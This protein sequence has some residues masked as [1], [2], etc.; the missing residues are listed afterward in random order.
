[1]LHTNHFILNRI[2]MTLLNHT[3]NIL[4]IQQKHQTSH[5]TQDHKF[6]YAHMGLWFQQ[7]RCHPKQALHEES[8]LQ[9]SCSHSEEYKAKKTIKMVETISTAPSFHIHSIIQ[10]TL[11]LGYTRYL[12]KTNHWDLTTMP[13]S[14]ECLS[15]RSCDP[16][17]SPKQYWS[18]TIHH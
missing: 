8:F 17:P 5:S 16:H 7:Q 10:A 15:L 2:K 18:C 9:V 6:D 3:S 1:M 4:I 12:S 13:E 11:N 14:E